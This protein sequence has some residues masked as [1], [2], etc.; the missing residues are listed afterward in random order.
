M[1]PIYLEGMFQI[2]RKNIKLFH[3]IQHTLYFAEPCWLQDKN[4]GKSFWLSSYAD[5]TGLG[6]FYI[7]LD[8]QG[9]A[10]N[11]VT[12]SK[13]YHEHYYT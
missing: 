12:Q 8:R 4:Q 13:L 5:F 3:C 11:R 7:E 10:T 6:K 9:S 1:F 2:K